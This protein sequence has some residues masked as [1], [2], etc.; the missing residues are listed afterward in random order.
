MFGLVLCRVGVG[1]VDGAQVGAEF[2]GV[3]A[4]VVQREDV[5][6]GGPGAQDRIAE[7]AAQRRAGLPDERCGDRALAE[8]NG[9]MVDALRAGIEAGTLRKVD[10]ED[11][12]TVLWSAWN[13]IISLA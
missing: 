8:Q 4:G 9:R 6:V 2:V 10:P 12:A 13:G 1:V 3:A 11:V 7:R 5:I